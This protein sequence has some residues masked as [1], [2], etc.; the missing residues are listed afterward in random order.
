M[1]LFFS[2][3]RRR[4]VV[5]V[6]RSESATEGLR[7]REAG[8]RRNEVVDIFEYFLLNNMPAGLILCL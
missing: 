4:V 3:R 1:F 2:S 7:R 5:V 8:S 6:F